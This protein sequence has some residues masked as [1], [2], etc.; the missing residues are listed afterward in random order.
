MKAKVI[1]GFKEQYGY[2]PEHLYFA[3]GRVNLIGEHLDYNGGHVLPFALTMGVYLAIGSSKSEV[4][5]ISSA[6]FHE[7][8]EFYLKNII[9]KESQQWHNYPR[10][11]IREYQ[12]IIPV[13]AGIDMYFD[14]DLPIG[15]GISSSAAIEVVTSFAI[16]DY[17]KIARQAVEH[18]IICKKVENEFVGVGCGIMDQM[19]SAIGRK[20]S[21]LLLNCKDLSYDFIPF[22]FQPC[23]LIITHTGKP[24]NLDGSAF[25]ERKTQCER[26]LAELKQHYDIEDLC[27]LNPKETDFTLIKNESARKRA[28]HVISE[29]ERVILASKSLLQGDL[30]KLGIL[31][32]QSHDSLRD[33]YEV[34]GFELDTIVDEARKIDGV[35]GA[36]MS[37]AGFGGCSINLVKSE[38][39]EEFKEVL[40]TQYE[41]KTG[42]K[43]TFFNA[44]SGNGAMKI[45]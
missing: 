34:T 8:T 27:D 19:I 1:K 2:L 17:Y 31:M 13:D 5:R 3:P 14:S 43:I 25:N 29:N 40:T 24:R 10:G 42:Y 7:N 39:T 28:M 23:E 15:A 30:I 32:N 36:R 12:N 44:I 20:N 18:S 41:S 38:N 11:V 22:D 4:F 45:V 21:C 16:C 26:A 6:Q 9:L 33:Y 35:L 37:G